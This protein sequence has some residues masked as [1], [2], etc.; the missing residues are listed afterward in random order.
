MIAS[1]LW[2]WKLTFISAQKE[3]DLLKRVTSHGAIIVV[4]TLILFMVT[5]SYHKNLAQNFHISMYKIHFF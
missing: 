2:K 4:F 1:V 3:M 5:T